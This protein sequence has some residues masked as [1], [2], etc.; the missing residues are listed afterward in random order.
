[1]SASMEWKVI[2]RHAINAD[3]SRYQ[4]T[5]HYFDLLIRLYVLFAKKNKLKNCEVTLLC[6]YQG[7]NLAIT[8]PIQIQIL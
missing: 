1:M 8:Q 5:L 6:F 3:W 2:T 7:T 4:I